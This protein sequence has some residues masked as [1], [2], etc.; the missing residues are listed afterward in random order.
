MYD[1]GILGSGFLGSGCFKVRVFKDKVVVGL[2][3]FRVRTVGRLLDGEDGCWFCE[4]LWD[5]IRLVKS[6]T[7]KPVICDFEHFIYH[8][9]TVRYRYHIV[10][11]WQGL[12]TNEI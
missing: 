4:S 1:K 8:P 7:L 11:D 9:R 6:R 2:G 10:P 3:S 5:G 12:A